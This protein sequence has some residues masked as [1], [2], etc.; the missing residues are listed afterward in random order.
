VFHLLLPVSSWILSF[1]D[2]SQRAGYALQKTVGLYA[3]DFDNPL[4]MT[5]SL[6]VSQ[7]NPESLGHRIEM[8][9]GTLVLHQSGSQSQTHH[10]AFKTFGTGKTRV[11]VSVKNVKMQ[12]LS[13]LGI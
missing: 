11:T 10:L 6:P 1:G 3:S 13:W 4:V 12:D 2:R 5:V 7:R 9:S 8:P